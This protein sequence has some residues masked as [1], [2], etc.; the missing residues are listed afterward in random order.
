MTTLIARGEMI[1]AYGH[2]SRWIDVNDEQ[3]LSEAEV[4]LSCPNENWPIFPTPWGLHG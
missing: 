4:L 2:R 1:A 3:A